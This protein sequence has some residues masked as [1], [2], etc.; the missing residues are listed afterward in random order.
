MTLAEQLKDDDAYQHAAPTTPL[1]KALFGIGMA[2]ME[3]VRASVLGSP[4]AL[5]DCER[6]RLDAMVNAVIDVDDVADRLV[7][8]A[9]SDGYDELIPDYDT[10]SEEDEI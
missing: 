2:H 5:A 7:N 10:A 3:S 6:R 9:A 1:G 4:E 8:G